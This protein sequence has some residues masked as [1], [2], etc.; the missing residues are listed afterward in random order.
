MLRHDTEYVLGLVRDIVASANASLEAPRRWLFSPRVVRLSYRGPVAFASDSSL[1]LFGNR[2]LYE[3]IDGGL[4]RH[5]FH[6]NVP[7]VTALSLPALVTMATAVDGQRIETI[8]LD[9]RDETSLAAALNALVEMRLKGRPTAA[10]TAV[11]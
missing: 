4:G 6:L 9:L 7:G 8:I 11:Q 10:E 1:I 2:G 3:V 5:N